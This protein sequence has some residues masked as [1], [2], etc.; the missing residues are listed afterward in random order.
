M[1]LLDND[2]FFVQGWDA[3]MIVVD[4]M[5]EIISGT[6]LLVRLEPA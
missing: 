6:V 4:H 5:R 2:H 1:L 3:A